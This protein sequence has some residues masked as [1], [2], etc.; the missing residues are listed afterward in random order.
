MFTPILNIWRRIKQS[1]ARRLVAL[2]YISRYLYFFTLTDSGKTLMAVIV[3]VAPLSMISL[4]YPVYQIL[5]ALG[6]FLFACRVMSLAF[7]PDVVLH[8]GVPEKVTAGQLVRVAF[9]ISNGG[10]RIAR[11]MSVGFFPVAL[12]ARSSRLEIPSEDDAPRK[13]K[14]RWRDRRGWVQVLSDEMVIDSIPAGASGDINIDLQF[15]RRG[16]YELPMLRV[17]SE[18]PFNVLRTRARLNSRSRNDSTVMALPDFVPAEGIEIPP[19]RNYQP[20]GISLTSD[21][22]ESPE[23]I[24]SRLYRPGDNVKRLDFR[25]WARHGEPVIREYQEEYFCR[26]ALILDTHVPRG[27]SN[28]ALEAAIQLSAAI[29]DALANGEYIIDIFAAGPD[30]YVFRAG[31]HTAHFENILEI[32]ACLEGNPEETF[33]AIGPS[34]R[35]EVE[36]IST[37]LFVFTDWSESRERLV[38]MAL[39]SGCN[40][41]VYVVST[42]ETALSTDGLEELVPDT[43]LFSATEVRSGEYGVL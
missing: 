8:G 19:S 27:Q 6:A 43:L 34:L 13:E 10:N 22:G 3:V 18:F 38:R 40:V 36:N 9:T 2:R 21:I 25:G 42:G 32:L 24:G 39:D 4:E 26:V 33:D 30:L 37:A 28:E 11:D 41:K 23:Y 1:N 15:T 12:G 16:I 5:V 7:R 29:T 35:N 14:K 31:R 17:Y 20:G